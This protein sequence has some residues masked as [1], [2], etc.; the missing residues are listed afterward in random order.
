MKKLI[1]KIEHNT[2]FGIVIGIIITSGIGVLALDY[3]YNSEQVS[4]VKKDSTELDVKSALDELYNLSDNTFEPTLLWT[5]PNIS[6]AFAAQ[7]VNLD[8][9]NYKAIYVVATN[10]INTLFKL[11]VSDTSLIYSSYGNLGW[12]VVTGEGHMYNRN[13]TATSTGVTFTNC[14]L[15]NINTRNFEDFNLFAIP[16]YIYGIK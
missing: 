6:T 15:Y 16:Q 2:L 11:N 7:T 3:V 5:N 9:S 14:R 1:D 4:Y 10:G 8:L 12:G 13:V